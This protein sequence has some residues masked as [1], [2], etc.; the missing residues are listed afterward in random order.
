MPDHSGKFQR[1]KFAR[2]PP[3]SLASRI[4]EVQVNDARSGLCTPKQHISRAWV[5]AE[6]SIRQGLDYLNR[7]DG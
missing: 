6:G 1:V 5:N 4:V 7:A 3:D 2:Q